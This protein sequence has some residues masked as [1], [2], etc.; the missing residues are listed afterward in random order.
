MSLNVQE[1]VWDWNWMDYVDHSTDSV[2]ESVGSSDS[3]P[4]L[5]EEQIPNPFRRLLNERGMNVCLHAWVTADCHVLECKYYVPSCWCCYDEATTADIGLICCLRCRR[6]G[7]IVW[8]HPRCI[9][10]HWA[11]SQ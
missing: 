2:A 5:I 11:H 10:E 7:N 8:L 9:I 1:S 3:L 4:D 6:A